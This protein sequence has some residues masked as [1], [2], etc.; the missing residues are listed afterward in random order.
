MLDPTSALAFSLYENKGIYALLVGSGLSSAAQIPTGWEITGDLVR[1][2]ALV[3]R[4]DEQ[5]DWVA[6]HRTEFGKEPEYLTCLPFSRRRPTSAGLSCTAILKPR[7]RI[8]SKAGRCRP[9]R[10]G[11]SRN[12]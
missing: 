6:W 5:P 4:V 11:P 8:F 9:R 7:L 2:A 3:Q 12:W 1:R 10:I